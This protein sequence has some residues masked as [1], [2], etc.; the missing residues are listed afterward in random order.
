MR[1][2]ALMKGITKEY[3]EFFGLYQQLEKLLD[4]FF[5]TLGKG[6]SAEDMGYFTRLRSGLDMS[7]FLERVGESIESVYSDKDIEDI[8]L[9]YRTNPVLMK[10]LQTQ[11]VLMAMHQ[12]AA[13]DMVEDAA[14]RIVYVVNRGDC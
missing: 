5:E 9:L 13:S 4:G 6:L 7:L 2:D 10:T 14:K 12:S 11:D 3:I 8:L 1:D